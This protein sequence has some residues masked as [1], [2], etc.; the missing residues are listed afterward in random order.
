MEP[1]RVTAPP[2]ERAHRGAFEIYP[3]HPRHGQH[4]APPSLAQVI[5][6]AAILGTFAGPLRVRAQDSLTIIPGTQYEAGWVHRIFF[7]TH[8]REAW[9]TPVRL[10][11][12]DLR[13]YAG[14]LTPVARGGGFQTKSLRFQ[15][16]DGAMYK[17]RSLDKDPRK[18]LP[19]EL[20]ESLV[21]DLFQDQISSANPYAQLMAVPLMNAVGV[22]NAEP[23]LVVLPQ[24]TLLGKFREEF[25]GL[26]GS[27]EEHP[28]ERPDGERG[29]SGAAKVVSSYSMMEKMEEDHRHRVSEREYLRARLMDVYLG[30]WDRHPD[31]WRWAGFPSGGGWEWLPIP[32]DRDQA[33]SRFDGVVPWIAEK[34]IPELTDFSDSYPHIND[35]TWTGHHMDRRLLRSLPRSTW[36]SLALSLQ[37]ALT[38]SVI[39]SAARRMPAALWSADGPELERVLLKR[40]DGLLWASGEFYGLV[41]KYQDLHGSDRAECALLRRYEDGR[42]LVEISDREATGA[43]AARPPFFSRVFSFEETKEI[44]LLMHGGDDSVAVEGEADCSPDLFIE[45][46]E[47]RDQLVDRSR[48]QGWLLGFVP[49]VPVT[50]TKTHFY[51]GGKK[52]TFITGPG[53]SVDRSDRPPPA[54][55][56]ERW[57]PPVRDFGHDWKFGPWFAITP[58]DGLFIGGGPILY[59]HGFRTDPYVSRLSLRA[60][61]ATAL[62]RFRLDFSGDFYS[63]IRGVRASLYVR[64]SGIDVINYYGPGN[65]TTA[66]RPKDVYKIRQQQLTIDPTIDLLPSPSVVVSLGLGIRHAHTEADPGTLLGETRPYGVDDISLLGLTARVTLDTRDNTMFPSSGVHLRGWGALVFPTWNNDELFGRIGGEAAGYCGGSSPLSVSLAARVMGE[67]VFGTYP[68]FEAA[69]LGGSPMLR[70][71][72]RQ[73]FAGDATA[74]AN[75][76]ARVPLSKYYVLIP[77]TIGLSAFAETGRVFLRGEQSQ[78]WHPAFGGGIWVSF[79]RRELTLSVTVARSAE[80]TGVYVTGGF[81]F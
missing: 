16:A 12:L 1:C 24:D 60:G 72:E 19:E 71:Y 22:L 28:D 53:T 37:A 66:E 5:A 79:V 32:R 43:R 35:L 34:S 70:G 4:L 25:A 65:E 38:D 68:Y 2:A 57:R 30:D 47:G 42:V 44:R 52:T 21:A 59:E 74:L 51:D 33:F 23:H 73:R 63:L 26:A 7:G 9:T 14:G 67:I 20:R 13:S 55:E 75:V 64:A 81:M 56:E 40:R 8:W 15:G 49:F 61:Y 45:G 29:F 46:G 78:R 76:E 50:R 39:A 69:M 58:D 6:L 80:A 17:F 11:V 3:R 36:D 54:T 62:K 10:P 41:T 27:I 18:C 77:G 48:V 31:Q